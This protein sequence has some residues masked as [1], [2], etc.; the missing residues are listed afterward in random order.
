MSTFAHVGHWLVDLLYVLPLLV[1]AAL[2]LAGRLRER[3]ESR[4][5]AGRTPQAPG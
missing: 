5:R 3:K 2:L 1:V 4:R